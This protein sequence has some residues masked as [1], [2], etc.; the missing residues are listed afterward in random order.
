MQQ[1]GTVLRDML[2]HDQHALDAGAAGESFEKTRH[3]AA[4]S[5]VGHAPPATGGPV[6]CFRDLNPAPASWQNG[7]TVEELV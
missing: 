5:M 7:A 1:L 4:G 2:H 3:G 6:G